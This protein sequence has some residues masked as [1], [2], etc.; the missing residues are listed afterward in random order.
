MSSEYTALNPMWN[1]M[2]YGIWNGIEYG[3]EYGTV[4]F[5][6]SS[7]LQDPLSLCSHTSP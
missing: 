2:E 3:M 7:I 4:L 1:G 5:P 6:K